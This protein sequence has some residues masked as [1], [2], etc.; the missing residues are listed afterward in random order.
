MAPYFVRG[1]SVLLVHFPPCNTSGAFPIPKRMNTPWRRRIV[2]HAQIRA[3]DLVP[4]PMNPRIHPDVQKTTLLAALNR[5]GLARS[6]LAR[7]LPDGQLRC[8]PR[9]LGQE[10]F[11]GGYIGILRP[12]GRGG[13]V[14]LDLDPIVLRR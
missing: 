3:G 1:S 4:H 5:L 2:E 10:R 9:L 13:G 12:N 7:R 11:N 6:V 14:V 8:W